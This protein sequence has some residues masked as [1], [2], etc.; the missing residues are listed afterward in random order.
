MGSSF[1][2]PNKIWYFTILRKLM[3]NKFNLIKK[4]AA[5]D[6]AFKESIQIIAK[7]AQVTFQR[8][9]GLEGFADDVF[10]PWKARK[11][12]TKKTLGKKILTGTGRLRRSIRYVIGISGYS[13]TV[14]TDVPYATIHND[15]GSIEKEANRKELHFNPNIR[16]GFVRNTRANRKEIGFR[17]IQ[18]FIGEHSINMPKRQFI[19]SNRRLERLSMAKIDAK[20]RTAYRNA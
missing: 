18:A 20:I 10:Q 12:E 5:V 14:F 6:R 16:G 7:D 4:A 19:G 13:A 2:A 17:T 3:A 9:F 1:Y 8:N 15:G 11:K